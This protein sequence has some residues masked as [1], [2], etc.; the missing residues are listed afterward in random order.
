MCIRTKTLKNETGFEITDNDDGTVK[1]LYKTLGGQ[2]RNKDVRR[3]VQTK[4]DE[5]PENH[6]SPGMWLTLNP[7]SI[8][9]G[10]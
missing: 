5:R 6:L 8:L 3:E 10:F 7:V 9:L 2:N 1:K 4:L